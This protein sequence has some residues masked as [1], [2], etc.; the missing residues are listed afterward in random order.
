MPAAPEPLSIAIDASA[1][2]S[3]RG[4]D[5]TYTAALLRSLGEVAGEGDVFHVLHTRD[6]PIP[7]GIASLE[8]FRFHEIRP[9][10][11]VERIVVAIPDAL[12]RISPR[13]QLLHSLTHAPPLSPVP[14]ALQVADLSYLHHPGFFRLRTRLRL[15]WLIGMQVHRV[16]AIT[17]VSEFSR[18]DIVRTYGVPAD[19]VHVIPNA[20][21]GTWKRN[22]HDANKVVGLG[23][24]YPY[25]LYVGGLDPR[26]NVARLIGAFLSA[27]ASEPRL[28]SHR[29]V[30]AGAKRWGDGHELDVMLRSGSAAVNFLGTVTD[31]ERDALIARSEALVYPSLFE[32]FG[33]PPIEAMALGTPVIAARAG[34]I[35][36]VTGD[37]A[38]LVDPENESEI[39]TAMVR[40][41]TD[42][43]LAAGLRLRGRARARRY[44]THAMGKRAMQAFR[45][46]IHMGAV[47]AATALLAGCQGSTP[48]SS[49]S[50]ALLPLSSGPLPAGVMAFDSNRTGGYEVFVRSLSQD[51]VM[52]LTR[53]PAQDSWWPRISP[54][55][56]YILYYR[57]PHG[58]HD[59]DFTKTS[60]WVMSSDGSGGSE[61]RAAGTDGWELQG[62]ADWS[63]DS[64]Q[65]VMF[66]GKQSN[67]Q[68]FIT[69]A[70]GFGSRKLTDRGGVNVDPSWSPDGK[71]IVFIGC[72]NAICFEKDYE[73]Y[74][75][76]AGGGN[77]TR[78]TNDSI[79]DQDPYYSPDGKQ[80]AWLS[81]TDTHGLAGLSVWNI[82]IMNADGSNQH[83]VTND[84][85]INSKPQWSP[86]GKL[87]Y[88][89]RF[90]PGTG[91]HWSIFSIRPDGGGMTDTMSGAPGDN[92]FPSL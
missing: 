35:P 77:A 55:R 83:L 18:D 91:K 20:V 36:E 84:R 11:K 39:C 60:L 31:A 54:D 26:K 34:A 14:V 59:T 57:T 38:L 24:T 45:A 48:H 79:R 85:N 12:R 42:G 2:G 40:V 22:G 25:F 78:L 21:D 6:A 50:P 68:I 72:P 90:Q 46:A 29:L 47:V 63:P 69:P 4:G 27:R 13:P 19:R 70:N 80:I 56:K 89:H 87:I 86:D 5:E 52:Q 51:A 67:P 66:G 41:A 65:I 92:E 71:T 30:I 43:E 7:D 15:K 28:A 62:H 37:A 64:K 53:D 44:S 74:T 75:I 49:S 88:F 33:L 1:L 3:G 16:R 76:P 73:V 58:V 9:I 10:S 61:L 8:A 17:T 82:R 81:E 23:V 32:G